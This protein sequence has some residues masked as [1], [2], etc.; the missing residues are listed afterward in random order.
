MPLVVLDKLVFLRPSTSSSIRPLPP[1]FGSSHG[2][3]RVLRSAGS[4]G[5]A[6]DIR[7][8]GRVL[9]WYCDAVEACFGRFLVKWKN[10]RE[11]TWEPSGNIGS[12]LNDVKE[13]WYQL[14]DGYKHQHAQT[15]R[16]KKERFRGR[17]LTESVASPAGVVRKV[18]R[19]RSPS[20]SSCEETNTMSGLDLILQH[21]EMTIRR[22]ASLVMMTI[23]KK[24]HSM[25]LRGTIKL[26]SSMRTRK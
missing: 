1:P 19:K 13:V 22:I 17:K 25:V 20:R 9:R 26:E 15:L 6:E 14:N 8:E 23:L 12:G 2:L 10:S 18:Y 4:V 21:L 3:T 7:E 11:L 16:Q 24:N 5:R